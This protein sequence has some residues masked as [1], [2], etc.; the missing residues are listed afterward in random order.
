MVLDRLHPGGRIRQLFPPKPG[1]FW[2]PDLSFDAQKV[3]FCFKPH[4]EKFAYQIGNWEFAAHGESVQGADQGP[5]MAE[6][7]V[8]ATV[9]LKKPGTLVAASYCNIHG[10]WESSRE[11]A[12]G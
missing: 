4:D 7:S 3:L 11:I 5:A 6:P 1:S 10:L 2:R 9:K 8:S 12:V